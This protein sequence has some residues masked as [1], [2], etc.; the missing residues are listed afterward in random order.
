MTR[1]NVQIALVFLFFAFLLF[2][3]WEWFQSAAPLPS[4]TFDY[5]GGGQELRR[6]MGDLTDGLAAPEG[7]R[8]ERATALFNDLMLREA[9]FAALFLD[10]A[11]RGTARRAYRPWESATRRSVI[12][13]LRGLG[14][15]AGGVD[16]L[17]WQ[18]VELGGGVGGA[19]FSPDE[20]A[21]VEALAR[22]RTGRGPQVF[23]AMVQAV[24]REELDDGP[25]RARRSIRKER[26]NYFVY[27]E[28][29]WVWVGDAVAA[30]LRDRTR[31]AVGPGGRG[32]G[33][34]GR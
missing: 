4:Y 18:I 9:D 25:H 33:G 14:E 26:F 21:L 27:S 7:E 8:Q 1:Q 30:A 19:D 22:G 3:G 6:L 24:S 31:D 10:E 16:S 15:Q 2:R 29:R 20:R 12:G 32:P 13:T 17:A 28:G 5:G 11:D 34:S 23:T